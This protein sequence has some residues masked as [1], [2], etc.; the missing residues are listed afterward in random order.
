M[1]LSRRQFLQLAP[2]ALLLPYVHWGGIVAQSPIIRILNYKDEKTITTL[3]LEVYLRYVVCGEMPCDWPSEALRAQA[4]AS[5]SYAA[6]AM[7]YPRHSLV[8]TGADVCDSPRHCQLF[9]HDIYA[10]T[11]DKAIRQ[12]HG[13][14]CYW[15]GQVAETM[16]HK[17]CGGHTI[18]HYHT[19]ADGQH[20][21]LQPYLAEVACSCG[22]TRRE[23]H[24]LGM[25]Q[26]G[27]KAMA[28]AGASY[29]EILLHY[30][31]GISIEP[32]E[33]K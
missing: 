19:A 6:Y 22:T 23:G 25:C 29:V 7:R 21:M 17:Q 5:R 8:G 31:S 4:V 26:Y 9:R 12:T 30:Y 15:R 32:L 10:G 28:E 18:E 13:L 11:T 3:P 14:V 27:A 1:L 33:L 16:Y 20:I 2:A 24:G